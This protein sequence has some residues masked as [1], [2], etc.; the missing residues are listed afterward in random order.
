MFDV[1]GGGDACVC[2]VRGGDGVGVCEVRGV[3]WLR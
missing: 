1:R 2:E 3:R